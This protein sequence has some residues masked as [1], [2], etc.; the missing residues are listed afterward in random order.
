MKLTCFWHID[1][2]IISCHLSMVL[3]LTGFISDAVR[4]SGRLYDEFVL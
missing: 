4:G 1:F 2:K 3:F